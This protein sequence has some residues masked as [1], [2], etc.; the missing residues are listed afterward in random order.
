MQADKK[1]LQEALE[2]AGQ[3]TEVILTLWHNC[4]KYEDAERSGQKVVANE[5]EAID[6]F[7]V[8]DTLTQL[9]RLKYDCEAGIEEIRLTEKDKAA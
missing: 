9:Q 8:L 6:P 2:A 7:T 4:Q 5:L 1:Q 3:A